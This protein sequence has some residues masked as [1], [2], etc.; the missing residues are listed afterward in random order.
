MSYQ[1][2][3]GPAYP[4]T[5]NQSFGAQRTRPLSARALTTNVQLS[6]MAGLM[7]G[8]CMRETTGAA[9]AV[10]EL[11]DGHDTTGAFVGTVGLGNGTSST[12]TAFDDGIEITVGL[13]AHVVTGTADVIVYYRID[14]PGTN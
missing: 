2:A 5:S 10:V 1:D 6:S 3:G 8:W 14:A 11:Y 13:Y 4:A 12:Y 7:V 9:G